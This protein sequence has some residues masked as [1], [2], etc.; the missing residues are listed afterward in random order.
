MILRMRAFRD[1]GEINPDSDSADAT[2]SGRSFRMAD[3]RES[4]TAAF[5]NRALGIEC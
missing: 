5:G 3:K 2:F 1:T 4:S